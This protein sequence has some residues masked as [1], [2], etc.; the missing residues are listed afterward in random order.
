MTESFLLYT[1]A[2]RRAISGRRIFVSIVQ[3]WRKFSEKNE[4]VEMKSLVKNRL[5]IRFYAKIHL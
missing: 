3:Q 4:G 1:P 5:K 2:Q